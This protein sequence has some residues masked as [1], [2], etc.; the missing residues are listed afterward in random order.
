MFAVLGDIDDSDS[1]SVDIGSSNGNLTMSASRALL[2]N[3]KLRTNS[4]NSNNSQQEVAKNTIGAV[5]SI[6][7]HQTNASDKYKMSNLG[8]SLSSKRTRSQSLNSSSA[9]TTLLSSSSA[10]H[11]MSLRANQ[12]ISSGVRYSSESDATSASLSTI[13][14]NGRN[15]TN[16]NSSSNNTITKAQRRISKGSN[17]SSLENGGIN[18]LPT[19]VGFS[20]NGGEIVARHIAMRMLAA[21][22]RSY[23]LQQELAKPRVLKLLLDCL[24]DTDDEI[25]LQ[26]AETI[27]N[28]AQNVETHLQLRVE[29]TEEGLYKLLCHPNMKVQYQAARGLVYMGHLDVNGKYIYNYIPVQDSSS[30]VVFMEEGGRSHVRGTTVENLVLTLT[31][32]KGIFLLWGGAHNLPPSPNQRKSSHHRHHQP[33]S[34]K[35]NHHHRSSK[36]STPSESQI[37]NFIL[38]TYQTFVHPIIF[39]RL[40]LHRFREPSAYERFSPLVEPDSISALELDNRDNSLIMGNNSSCGPMEH[41]AP[42]P[43]V[44]ARLM[45]VWIAWLEQYPEDFRGFPTLREELAVLIRP[46]RSIDGPYAPCASKL[47][48]LLG[49]TDDST[50]SMLSSNVYQFTS[51]SHHNVLYEQCYKAIKDGRLPCPDDDCVY[52]VS[53][54]LYIEDLCLYGQDFAERLKTIDSITMSRLKQNGFGSS[55]LSHKHML[56]KIKAQYE[57]S[58]V[59]TC[60]S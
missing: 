16:S 41:Y 22:S 46:M 52:L 15:V 6:H 35:H 4:M 29:N 30:T 7:S 11:T 8:S 51:E 10:T 45:R 1:S 18:K 31:Q 32:T 53:L 13:I 48:Q 60:V 21:S 44:H 2:L 57:V 50:S 3:T 58:I 37:V 39:M 59:E 33:S 54:Q 12:K 38:S 24:G 19:S 26:S 9:D 27:A 43:I 34:N 47:E 23:K 56:K 28:I 14:N 25:I 20:H 5:K 40:L 42:L 55:Q 49:R 17:C 36:T